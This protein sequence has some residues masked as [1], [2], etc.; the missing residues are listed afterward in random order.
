MFK[1]DT[2]VHT[3]ESSSCG[4]ISGAEVAQLYKDAGY[5]G[6]VITDHYFRWGFENLLSQKWSDKV[7]CFLRGYRSALAESQSNGLKVFL[8]ME[9]RF[10]ENP[11]DYLIYSFDEK[12]LYDN[13]ELYKLGLREFGILAK[14]KNILIFQAHPFRLNIEPADPKL[15]DGVEVYNCNPRH[16]ARNHLSLQ[17]AAQNSLLELSGSDFHQMEDL[18]LGGIETDFPLK[19]TKDFAKVL[20]NKSYRMIVATK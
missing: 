10:D 4:L 6:I 5:D 15:L 14:K 13:P 18:A 9:I 19:S 2:H 3:K 20:K 17:Y 16:E 8:G 12:F 11:N 7:D 1:Y